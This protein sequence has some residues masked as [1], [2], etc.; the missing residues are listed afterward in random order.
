VTT[1]L[2][3]KFTGPQ[4]EPSHFFELEYDLPKVRYRPTT[5][6]LAGPTGESLI[7]LEFEAFKDTADALTVKIKNDEAAP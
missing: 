7:E 5:R 6:R 1:A 3:I 2:N 4:I